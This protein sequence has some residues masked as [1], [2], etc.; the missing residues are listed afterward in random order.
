MEAYIL[1]GRKLL[2]N[3]RTVV[4]TIFDVMTEKDCRRVKIQSTP[5]NSSLQGEIEK[6]S[7]YREFELSRVKLL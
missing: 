3:V 2:V 4:T 7:S 5:D 1:G 6:S